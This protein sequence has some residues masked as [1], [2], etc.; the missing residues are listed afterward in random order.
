MILPTGTGLRVDHNYVDDLL[1]EFAPIVADRIRSRALAAT[2]FSS[3]LR[4]PARSGSSCWS[5]CENPRV[6]WAR[7]ADE[8]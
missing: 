6:W 3:A 1:I 7:W 5:R 8:R 4:C 2:R